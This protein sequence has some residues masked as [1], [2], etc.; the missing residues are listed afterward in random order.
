[1]SLRTL[2]EVDLRGKNVLIRLDLNVPMDSQGQITDDTR[3]RG[4]LP[5]LKAVL[6]KTGKVVL[7]S[8][9]GRPKG[10][11]NKRYSLEPVGRRLAELLGKLVG[12]NG[13]RFLRKITQRI[14]HGELQVGKSEKR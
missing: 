14:C 11:V 1:M 3:I 4:C 10:Q 9:L 8:H 5:T 12:Q 7:M 13:V 6:E 2:S